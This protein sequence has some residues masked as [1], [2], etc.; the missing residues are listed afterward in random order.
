MYKL[1]RRAPQAFLLILLIVILCFTSSSCFLLTTNKPSVTDILDTIP[2]E[3]TLT[4][5]DSGPLT[6]DPAISQEASS[7]THIIQLFS[8]LVT[9]DQDMNLIP[10]IAERWE[11]SEDNKTYTFY[12]RQG[13]K[14]HDGKEI[15]ARDFKY[16]W[17][18]ACLPETDSPTAATYLNDIVG[19]KE[20]LDGEATEME[21]V[22]V[23]D[24]Y[25]LQVTIDAPKAYFL[26][27]LTYP[28]AFVVDEANV[29]SGKEWWRRPN[30]TGPF[31]LKEWRSGELIL[32][33]RN[34]LYY[35]EK[36]KVSYVAFVLLGDPMQMY[37][38]DEI[39]VTYVSTAYLER[40][41]DET[42]SLHQELVEAPELSIT[43]IAFDTTKPPFNNPKVRQA[44]C[45]AVN[46]ERVLSQV[47]K[48]SVT[49]AE[50]ILPPEMPGYNEEIEG[51][52]YNLELAKELITEAG[53]GDGVN[54]PLLTFTVP[55]GGGYVPSWLTAILY[56]WEQNLRDFGVEIEV[57]EL[58]SDVYYYRLNEEKDEAFFFGWVA[59][60]ADPQNFLEILFHSQTENNKGEYS[61]TE[62]D[63]LLEQAAVEQDSITR[64]E[65]Y[66]QAE[67]IIVSDAACL[68]LWFGRNYILV[69]PY[70]KGYTL[71]PL[72]I[73]LLT[74]VSIE[75][76]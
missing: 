62:V 28:V 48:D 60:Y 45:Y 68:P 8:G 54:L 20:M 3:D 65:L 27:K 40:V 50:G 47:L 71:S 51:L 35:R 22:Q 12:L 75:S 52:D 33:E 21:G 37:E 6:L 34:E 15:T 53:Y 14:F 63:A 11:K 67:Q 30:G 23:I 18:R 9:F 41:M 39:D 73:P 24:D 69:K 13:V 4:L 64:F 32:L 31:K 17:E 58:E 42:N 49:Q 59:D 46:K 26:A 43:Y 57:R 44:L 38:L 7:H 74:N 16:S 55:G 1:S 29:K 10:D 72:G 25:T 76:H 36:A 56:Q 66:Q 70:V 2:H 19:A 5:F 61:N